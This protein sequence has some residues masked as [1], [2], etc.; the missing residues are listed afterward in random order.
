MDLNDY[1]LLIEKKAREA[2][3]IVN[4]LDIEKNQSE[5]RRILK[6]LEEIKKIVLLIRALKE[7]D[8]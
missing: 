4:R 8:K 5:K 1:L 3:T 7:E 6:T 2:S